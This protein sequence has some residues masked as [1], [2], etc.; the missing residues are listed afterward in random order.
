M[1]KPRVVVVGVGSIGERHVRC[2]LA[3]GRVEVEFVETKATLAEE[4]ARRYDVKSHADLDSILAA[5]PSAAVIATPAPLH[6]LQA[7]RLVEAG[8]P[9]LIEKPL[10]ISL[11]GVDRLRNAAI[12]RDVTVGVAYVYRSF[13]VLVSMRDALRSGRFGT[14]RQLVAVSG[15]HFPTYRPAYRE[16]YYTDRK[17]GGGAIQDALTHIINMGEWLVGPV[18]S[19]VAD[20]AHQVLPGVEVEDTVHA[21]TRQGTVLGSYSLNQHQAP[22]E[23]TITINCD[24]GTLR[25]E[26]H[27]NRWLWMTKPGEAWQEEAFGPAERDTNFIA[28]AHG[29]LDALERK[30]TPACSLDEGIQT[31]KVN[32]AILNSV[33]QETWQT[34]EPG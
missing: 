16:I 33:E 10:S 30:R 28:Q 13:P 9:V 22:N 2:F 3:T 31:L 20:A 12:E 7:T 24:Q 6:V 21:L 29:F 1:A 27:N 8:I 34:I 17:L 15:Q 19:V 14:P 23:S 26:I 4:I 11:G 25:C 32:L 5:P 18:E